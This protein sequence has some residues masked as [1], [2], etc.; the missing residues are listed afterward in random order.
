MDNWHDQD[1][2]ELKVES[3]FFEDNGALHP[4]YRFGHGAYYTEGW[5]EFRRADG[6]MHKIFESS[7]TSTPT[8]DYPAAFW[9]NPFEN[10]MNT[11]ATPENALTDDNGAA[12]GDINATRVE[13]GWYCSRVCPIRV[14]KEDFKINVDKRPRMVTLYAI[15]LWKFRGGKKIETGTTY[16]IDFDLEY[17]ADVDDAGRAFKGRNRRGLIEED[18]R[19]SLIHVPIFKIQGFESRADTSIKPQEN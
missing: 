17:M 10:Q 2:E 3:P 4:L 1:I 19:N 8:E 7:R 12:I 11:T 9:F 13:D 14:E 6:T 16:F 15:D 18:S 5:S